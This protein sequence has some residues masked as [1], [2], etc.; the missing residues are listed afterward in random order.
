MLTTRFRCWLVLCSGAAWLATAAL[1]A[2]DPQ[3]WKQELAEDLP[4]LGH[5]NW[6]VVADS[7]YPAQTAPG[8]RTIYA[9]GDHPEAV[10]YVLDAVTHAPH[11]RPNVYLDAE[12]EYVPEKYAQGIGVLRRRLKTRLARHSTQALPHE[13]LIAKLDAAGQKF[14]VI[15]IK[16]DLDLPYTSVFIEL[17]AGYWSSEAEAALREAMDAHKED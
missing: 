10:K 2:A 6:I 13:E 8:I 1:H 7:A 4:L 3:A 17:E 15:I 11:V 9:G 5:R 14:Q 12:L 16:T